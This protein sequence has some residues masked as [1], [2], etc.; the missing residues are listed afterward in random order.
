[1]QP[2][3]QLVRR[4]EAE[5]QALDSASLRRRG[6]RGGGCARSQ[7]GCWT[8]RWRGRVRSRRRTSRGSPPDR[9]CCTLSGHCP[10][11]RHRDRS[12]E[13]PCRGL[14][15]RRAPAPERSPTHNSKARRRPRGE[16]ARALRLCRTSDD[17]FSRANDA[18]YFDR[19]VSGSSG[20]R[21]SESLAALRDLSIC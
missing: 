10:G 9:D 1:M 19:S 2:S 17:A 20:F 14:C 6:S 8:P 3:R 7:A 4:A 5:V 16:T 13:H 15:E 18:H 12:E 11:S 21:V